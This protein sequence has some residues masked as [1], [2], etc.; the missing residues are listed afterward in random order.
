MFPVWINALLLACE[1]QQVIWLRCAKISAGGP[2]ALSE[3]QLMVS[4]KVS[5]SLCSA[6]RLMQGAPVVS[7]IS[8]Y[9]DIVQANVVRLREGA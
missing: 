2:A 3:A 7:V 8:G 6:G 9:R 5:E 1:S 4:E